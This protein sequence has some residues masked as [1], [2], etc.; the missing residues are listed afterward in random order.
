MGNKVRVKVDGL[1]DVLKAIHNIF[2]NDPTAERA[3]LSQGMAA[4]MRKHML[5]MAKQLAASTNKS[6]ALSESLAVRTVAKKH[7]RY[8]PARANA[9]V[10][11]VPVRMNYKAMT[12]Y[13]NYYY[14]RK[15]K[16]PPDS[17]W[18]SGIRHG[19]LVEFGSKNNS[20]KPY[21]LPAVKAGK[22]SFQDDWSKYLWLKTKARV[23]RFV[24]KGKKVSK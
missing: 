23:R 12:T 19:H 4:S 9:A 1:Q 24:K 15:G 8:L 20:P 13:I 16:L 14:G 2:P 3:L 7:L 21:I 6:G 11:L 18:T 10:R 5:P 22:A 17:I